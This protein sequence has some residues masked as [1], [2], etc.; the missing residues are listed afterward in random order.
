MGSFGLRAAIGLVL[1]AFATSAQ[2][3]TADWSNYE[4][5]TYGYRVDIPA[6]QFAVR[7]QNSEKLTLQEVGGLGEIDVYG[8]TNPN[9]AT[10]GEFAAALEHATR[11]KDITYRASG[12][13]WLV[14]SGHYNR[15]GGEA[16]DLIFY[17]KFMFSADRSLLSAFEISYPLRLKKQFDP[18]V[19]RMERTLRAPSL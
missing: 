15:E 8:A 9:R 11:I 7:E 16:E 17:A 2:A 5:S 3:R 14:L 19:A 13:G 18:V 6:G 1:L 4:N 12:R 10:P